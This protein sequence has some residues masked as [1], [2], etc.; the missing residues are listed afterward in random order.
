MRG[1]DGQHLRKW[2]IFKSGNKMEEY[3][4][5]DLGQVGWES[6]GDLAQNC[7]QGQALV[8]TGG[9]LSSSVTRALIFLLILLITHS[10]HEMTLFQL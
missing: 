5:T 2:L 9:K 10:G 3:S 1:N 6:E 4:I 8:V 7:V